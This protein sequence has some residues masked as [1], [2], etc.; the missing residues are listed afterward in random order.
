MCTKMNELR[1]PGVIYIVSPPTNM[2]HYITYSIPFDLQKTWG[3][4][5]APL[6]RYTFENS[7]SGQGGAQ[8]NQYNY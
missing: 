4:S 3:W 5:P 2:Q 7:G 1:I 6:L 8:T